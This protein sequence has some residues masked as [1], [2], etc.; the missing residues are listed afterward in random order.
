MSPINW[1]ESPVPF[2]PGL[3][4]SERFYQE[5]VRPLLQRFFPTLP[6]SAALVGYG[7][8]VLGFDTPISRDHMWGP[9]LVLF[10]ETEGFSSVAKAVDQMLRDNLPVEFAGYPT[11]FGSPGEDEVRVMEPVQ[12]GPVDH[13]VTFQTI[14]G[15]FRQVLGLEHIESVHFSRW[16]TFP[17]Q[18]LLE[19]TA[20]GVFHDDLGLIEL[21]ER[22]AFFPEPVWLYLLASQW[23][24]IAQEEAFIGRTGQVGDEVGSQVIAASMVQDLMC[25]AF[26]LERRY[27]PY[28]KWFGSAFHRLDIAERLEPLLMRALQA[29][30]WQAREAYLIEAAVLLIEKQNTLKITRVLSPKATQFYGRPF[31]VLF[32]D[33]IVEGL[34]E[35]ITDP[36]LRKLPLFGSID[37]FCR[38]TDVLESSETY[39]FLSG[40]FEAAVNPT[41]AR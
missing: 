30:H 15:F 12:H 39:G 27:A 4:L 23:R 24:R 11:H 31:R 13:L 22:F 20:G 16:L 34:R 3:Q 5:A 19:V 41:D 37:Q 18:K 38:T 29:P 10:L 25:L 21:R 36:W 17:Q 7:S 26:L 6:H 9:R 1:G 28:S 2:I 32:A 8:D 14:P 40:L 33:R 35:R